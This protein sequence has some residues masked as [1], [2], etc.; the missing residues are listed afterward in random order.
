MVEVV[1]ASGIVL[2]VEAMGIV[3]VEAGPIVLEA[4]ISRAAVAETGMPLAAVP[5]DTA[6]RAL[7][8]AVTVAPPVWALAEEEASVV[9]AEGD[10]AGSWLTCKRQSQEHR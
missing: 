10:D 6:D 9:E 2:G 7:A 4:E 8:P 1:E 5:V 3:Q